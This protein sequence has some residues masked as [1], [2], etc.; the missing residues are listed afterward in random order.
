MKLDELE[1]HAIDFLENGGDLPSG[2]KAEE[3]WKVTASMFRHN[4]IKMSEHLE[5]K[6]KHQTL[7]EQIT[8][9]LIALFLLAVACV[10]TVIP[11]DLNLWELI[12][13]LLP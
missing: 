2:L 9:K 3:R 10:H 4:C 12:K 5:D 8:L 6:D 11:A 13:G 7:K 1:Q